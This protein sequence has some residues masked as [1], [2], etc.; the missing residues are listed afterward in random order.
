MFKGVD[1]IESIFKRVINP[2][3]TCSI[4]DICLFASILIFN[5]FSDTQKYNYTM[6]VTGV[7]LL[8]TIG[9]YILRKGSLY[10]EKFNEKNVF[11]LVIIC[12]A[13][14]LT[15]VLTYEIQPLVDYAT[16]IILR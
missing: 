3:Y 16:F 5:Y 8:C 9:S 10:L 1:S 11:V 2:L 4:H 7:V 13:V 12:L 15:W 6:I 14:K